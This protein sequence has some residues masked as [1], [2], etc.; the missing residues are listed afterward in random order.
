MNDSINF[1][2]RELEWNHSVENLLQ[3]MNDIASIHRL[4]NEEA[5]RKYRKLNYFFSLP[6]II[7]STLTGTASMGSSSLFGDQ[8]VASIV[9]GG[10]SL[11]ISILQ[12]ISSSFKLEFLSGQYFNSYKGFDQFC[13]DLL[14]ELSLP[15]VSRRPV[16]DFLK[17]IIARYNDLLQNQPIIPKEIVDKYEKRMKTLKDFVNPFELSHLDVVIDNQSDKSDDSSNIFQ[18]KFDQLLRKKKSTVQEISPISSIER[19]ERVLGVDKGCQMMSVDLKVLEQ[20][21]LVRNEVEEHFSP[22]LGSQEV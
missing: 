21:E 13:R 10:V 15:R 8:H 4:M 1:K 14:L 2:D 9:I 6:V 16:S 12:T 3:K 11:F 20:K 19:K 7:L 22:V 17:S 18:K 5:Y